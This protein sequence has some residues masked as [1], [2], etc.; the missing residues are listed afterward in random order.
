MTASMMRPVHIHS[1]QFFACGWFHGYAEK[2]GTRYAIVEGE[3]GKT[4]TY[5]VMP[6]GCYWLEFPAPHRFLGRR[7]HENVAVGT[8][9]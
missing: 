7:Q 1:H 8:N 4:S 9:A 2:D 5:E 3:S 6:T